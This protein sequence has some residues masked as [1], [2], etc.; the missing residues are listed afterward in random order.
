MQWLQ[1]AFVSPEIQVKSQDYFPQ[2]SQEIVDASLRTKGGPWIPHPPVPEVR[3][4]FDCPPAVEGII[5]VTG[6]LLETPLEGGNRSRVDRDHPNHPP[7]KDQKM[8]KNAPKMPEKWSAPS[9]ESPLGEEVDHEAC[10][11]YGH[12][13]SS[14]TLKT[15]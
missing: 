7:K 6:M 5:F 10:E 11:A 12:T 8:P 15:H 2:G 14:W 1:D 3:S 13:E 4:Q 9:G